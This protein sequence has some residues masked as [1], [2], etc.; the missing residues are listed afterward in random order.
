MNIC[1]IKEIRMHNNC[2][3]S[4]SVSVAT[5]DPTSQL[6]RIQRLFKPP[7]YTHQQESERT[8]KEKSVR[9]IK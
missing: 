3:L 1:F 5:N 9:K 2:Y 6:N 7:A 4:M 8:E